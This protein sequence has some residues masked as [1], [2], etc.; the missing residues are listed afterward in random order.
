MPDDLLFDS[1]CADLRRALAE[2]GPAAATERLVESLARSGQYDALFYA[3]L[4]QARQR[5][6]ADPIP[7]RPANELPEP[8]HAPYEEAIRKAAR[9]VGRHYLDAGDIPHAWNYYRLIGEPQPVRE[10]LDAL[11]LGEDDDLYPLVEIALNQGVHPQKGFELILERQGICNAITTF[12]GFAAAL[13]PDVRADCARRLVLALHEQLV[14]RLRFEIAQQEGKLPETSAVPELLAGR[15]WLFGEDYYPIDVSH[16]GAVVQASVYLPPGDPGLRPAI[17]LCDVGARLSPKLKYAGDPPF[18]D[19][20]RD[21]GV[22]LRVLAGE[23]VE[24]G[25]AHFRAKAAT[26]VAERG[27]LPAEV[28]VNLLV[29]TGRQREALEAARQYLADVDERQLSCPG[30]LELSRRLGDFATFAEVARARGDA[31]HFL[32]GLLHQGGAGQTPA[33]A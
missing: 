5:L 18:E 33:G 32:A 13:A 26:M 12:G 4:L 31:V 1:L 15:D 9:I 28:L 8:L 6:G 23:D 22:F 24:A 2:T 27:T 17:E 7:S 20:Y 19:L 14:E 3:L 21:H 30:P 11:K 29:L 10:A 16:L 25:L